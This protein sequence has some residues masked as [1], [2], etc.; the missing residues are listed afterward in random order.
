[1]WSQGMALKLAISLA[2]AGLATMLEAMVIVASI[3]SPD[4]VEL[5]L[6]LAAMNAIT[7]GVLAVHAFVVR[8]FGYR[9]A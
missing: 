1:M 3:G 9:L 4:W 6:M 7:F 8:A 5:V 2:I